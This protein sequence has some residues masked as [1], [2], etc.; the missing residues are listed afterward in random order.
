M[1]DII[2]M[3]RRLCRCIE[4]IS[5][6]QYGPCYKCATSVLK[7]SWVEYLAI[8]LEKKP[9]LYV[10]KWVLQERNTPS[11]TEPHNLSLVLWIKLLKAVTKNVNGK[12]INVLKHFV[13]A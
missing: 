9:I 8:F 12:H 11:D 3:F 6:C 5:E 2:V 13:H 4:L 7:F 1:D 10:E